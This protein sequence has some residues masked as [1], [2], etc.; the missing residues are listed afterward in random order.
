MTH[1]VLQGQWWL[2]MAHTVGSQILQVKAKQ[3]NILG[4]R[5]HPTEKSGAVVQI[6]IFFSVVK[7]QYSYAYKYAFNG[8]WAIEISF[9]NSIWHV[10]HVMTHE[11][12]QGQWWLGMAHT[13]GSQILQIKQH[14]PRLVLGCVTACACWLVELRRW[15]TS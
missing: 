9:I 1:E 7:S 2:G 10:I 5:Q 3:I 15:I 11:V 6:I 8:V 4:S 14:W 12:L 13:V